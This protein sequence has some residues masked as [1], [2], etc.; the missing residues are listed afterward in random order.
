LVSWKWY[1]PDDNTW[2]PCENLKDGA[3]DAVREY[4]LDNPQ[5]PRDTEVLV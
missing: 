2:E 3:E 4:H 1:A 5:R